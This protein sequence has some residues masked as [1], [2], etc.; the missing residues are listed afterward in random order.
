MKKIEEKNKKYF[1]NNTESKL[2]K[3]FIPNPK[4]LFHKNLSE[5]RINNTT[6][7]S[8]YNDK[9]NSF[10]NDSY[11]KNDFRDNKIID[12]YT[13]RIFSPKK[14]I[15][16]Y[17]SKIY[18]NSNG[19]KTDRNTFNH[20]PKLMKQS[21]YKTI[22]DKSGSISLKNLEI[23]SLNQEKYQLNRLI[24]SLKKE[25]F[26][27]K[28]DS[29]EKDEILNSKDKEITDIINN[30]IMKSDDYFLQTHNNTLQFFDENFTQNN[31]N[32]YLKIKKEIKNFNNEMELEQKKIKELKRSVYFTKLKEI[33]LEYGLLEQ[34]INK[35]SSLIEIA[36][37]TK[38]NNAKKLEQNNDLENKINDQK[39]L[40]M[41]SNKKQKYLN[42]EKEK[43]NK[44]IKNIKLNLATEEDKINKNKKELKLRRTKNNNL[45][46]DEVIKSK[47]YIFY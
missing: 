30:T 31:Y 1:Q 16:N 12:T 36:Y 25:L 33:K 24:K 42:E 4:K 18:K 2:F 11:K 41:E 27:I 5:K 46:K 19:S 20:L 7:Y 26:L 9:K 10:L 40:L 32:F 45:S 37:K 43:L 39:K 47:I 6:L 35:I 8:L 21:N 23:E 14:T 22:N 29:Q 38:E 44:E 3:K 15:N 17:L 13:N 28:K 34:Q